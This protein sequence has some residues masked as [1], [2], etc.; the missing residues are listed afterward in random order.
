[1]LW[2]C[3][4]SWF[5]V[6]LH[7]ASCPADDALLPWMS[8]GRLVCHLKSYLQSS[9]LIS[10]GVEWNKEVE[11][12]RDAE[13]TSIMLSD[14]VLSCF[15]ILFWYFSYCSNFHFLKEIPVLLWKPMVWN[16]KCLNRGMGKKVRKQ[17]LNLIFFIEGFQ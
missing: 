15:L 13:N 2:Q 5:Q 11:V 3:S 6:Q 7:C 8:P 9:C 12:D 14:N 4:F 10:Q 17:K 16:Q 1:M